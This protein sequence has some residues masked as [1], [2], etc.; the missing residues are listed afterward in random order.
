MFESNMGISALMQ[1]PIDHVAFHLDSQIRFH[2]DSISEVL[3][4]MTEMTKTAT[5]SFNQRVRLL[6]CF[7]ANSELQRGIVSASC[8]LNF[9]GTLFVNPT[10][11]LKF[12]NRLEITAISDFG[13]IPDAEFIGNP[14]IFVP[15]PRKI[16]RFENN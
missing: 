13:G 8:L 3:I 1:G 7:T 12:N 6:E 16:V 5:E 11:A 9:F 2:K 15:Y 4:S 14:E 10:A